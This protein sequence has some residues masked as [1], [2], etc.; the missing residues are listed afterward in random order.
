MHSSRM[1]TAALDRGGGGREV[2]RG[3]LPTPHPREQTK[4]LPI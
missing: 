3:Y 2:G 4:T 1:R